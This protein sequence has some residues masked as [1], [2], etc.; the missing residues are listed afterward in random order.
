MTYA[1][2]RHGHKLFLMVD[3]GKGEIIP[4]AEFL[5]DKAADRFVEALAMA[6]GAAHAHGQNGI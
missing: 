4:I 5:S 1:I 3:Y 2:E 6:K